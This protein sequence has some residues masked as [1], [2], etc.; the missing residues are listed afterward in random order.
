[1]INTGI[2][3]FEQNGPLDWEKEV[4]AFNLLSILTWK[5]FQGPIHLYCN[6]EFLETLKKWKIDHLYDYINTDL[7]KQKPKDIDYTQ[8]FAFS[9]LLVISHLKDKAPFTLI[10]NDLWILSKLDFNLD[11]DVIMYH[12]EDFDLNDTNN[13]YPDF[14]VLIPDSIKQLNLDKSV[15]PTNGAIMH[16][17]NTDYVKEWYDLS[18]EIAKYNQHIKY[19]FL[20]KSVRMC[21]IEQR[22]LPMLIKKN[23]LKS[24]T[25]IDNV[26]LSYNAHRQDG[27]EWS[28]NLNDS[29]SDQK[30]KFA[31]IKHVWGLKK[32]LFHPQIYRLV[33]GNFLETIEN[34]EFKNPP[35]QELLDLIESDHNQS[36]ADSNL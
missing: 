26:Y 10:D 9:K 7:I 23:N 34:F 28:P 33:M 18:Y 29:T 11:S 22:L 6:D 1:M 20:N 25:L 21:F 32:F 8:Y 5:N 36:L 15:N 24:K 16:F 13:V 31:I 3:V 30:T 14:D 27:S 19:D 17:R 35:F 2:H 12:K 4:I